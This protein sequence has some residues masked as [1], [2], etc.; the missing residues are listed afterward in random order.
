MK[1]S[2]FKNYIAG[3]W[4]DSSSGET[5]ENHNPANTEDVIGNFPAAAKEDVERAIEAANEALPGWANTP[6]PNRGAILDKMSQ[7]LD[8]RQD[9]FARELTREE[10]KTLAEAK[11]EVLRARDIFKYYAGEGWRMGGQV[12]P[13][14]TAGELLYTRREA[15]G[16][17]ALITPWNFPIAIPVWKMAPALVYGNTVVFKP[18]SLVPHS[19]VLL[20][21]ALIEA[22][23]PKGVVNLV[24]GSG[25]TVGD[26]LVSSKRIAGISFT[27]SVSVGMGIY[28]KAMK[29]L[30]RVQLE[31]G[32]K[33]PT[34]VLR[35]ADISKAVNI[36]VAGG[37][38][39]TGQACTATSR[40][41]VEEAAADAFAQA[42]TE[43]ARN[44]K[45]GS[46]LE[47]GIQMG[48]AVSEDQ[49][50]TDLE[51]IGVG[52]QEGAKLLVGG[53][54]AGGNGGYFVQPTVFDNVE[55][56][57]RIA[58]EEIFGP[59]IGIIRAK[60]FDDAIEKA[61]D[62]GFGLSASIVTN[63]LQKAFQFANRIEAGV[64]KINEPTTGLALQA[65]FGG[66]KNSSAN[67]F[68]EQG[69]AA[70]EFYTRT[71]TVYVGHG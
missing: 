42:L 58:Q 15:L 61:N 10:G 20:V 18:A 33:N 21:E 66:F 37:F 30:T 32:G 41:I 52:R 51:Y 62:I 35:D 54:Q 36:A 4:V 44:L 67:T 46:G 63:D 7:I 39:L 29:N 43:A 12:L 56:Q 2:H 23:V 40:V 34:I 3:E 65:P 68:K 70:I 69:Q 22:G 28:E 57:M 55:P 49:L 24:T 47:S 1:M 26:T 60:D 5:F 27:G 13:S 53:G 59:V 16:A 31:M 17:V 64:V 50:Q 25:R 38:G 45:V 6:P 9:E 71:K 19:A 11:G 8:A 48:P 14:N